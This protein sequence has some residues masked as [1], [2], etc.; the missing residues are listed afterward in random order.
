MPQ[1]QPGNTAQGPHINDRP[2]GAAFFQTIWPGWGWAAYLLPYVE[3]DNLYQQIDFTA[4][5]VGTQAATIRVTTLNIYT[6]PSDRSTGNYPVFPFLGSSFTTAATNSYTACY[7][8]LGGL[9]TAPDKGN[10]LFLCNSAFQF[11][12]IPDGSSNTLAIGERAALYA[13][14]PWVG[15][16]DHG[17]VRTTTGAPVYQAWVSPAQAMPMARFGHHPLNDPWSECLD[18]FSPHPTGMNALFADGS[19]RW[20]K[21]STDVAVLQAV[22]SRNGG[23]AT[24]LPE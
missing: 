8:A 4:P 9:T 11:K 10:G 22:G 6:C 14:S 24:D 1:P 13:R 23:E 7:G 12:D 15:V 5:T 3:Q 16:I 2:S 19:V 20:V 17:T 18:F 21:T